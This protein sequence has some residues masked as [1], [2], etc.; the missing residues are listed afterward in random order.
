MKTKLLLLVTVCMMAF[1]V[2]AQVNSVA[3][4]GTA[5]GGW[6][7]EPGN[8]G[9]TDINQLT[10]VDADNWIIENITIAA[11]PCKLRANNCWCGAGFEWAG[12]FPT[13]TGT[14]SGDIIVPIAGVYTVTL[15]ATT[16]VYNFESGSP[17]PVVKLIGSSVTEAGGI[18]LAPF[19]TDTFRA[20]NVT[21]V[22]GTGQFDIDG[23]VFG[24]TS[25]PTGTLQGNADNIPVV[26][27]VYSTVTLNI[28]TGDYSFELAPL[29]PPV[30]IVGD[31]VGGW[32]GSTGNPGPEDT[33]QL[34][35]TD[36]ENYKIEKLACVVGPAK[37]RQDNAWT[38]NWGD[39][40][41]PTGTGTQGGPDIPVAAAGTY[42][43]TF[44]RSTGAYNF[45]IP[46][47]AIV[48]DAVGGWPGSTGN[49]GPEDVH[50]MATTDGLTYTISN[51]NVV[52][53]PAKFRQGNAWDINWGSVDF[54]SG[55]ATQNGADISVTTA[56]TYD[57]TLNRVTG[58]YNFTPS[59]A[60]TTFNS[61]NF[62][63]SPN[64][65]NN[66]WNF[67]SAKQ[68]IESIQIV[69]MLGKTVMTINPKDMNVTVDATSLNAGMYFAKISTANATETAKLIKN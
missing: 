40:A 60:T 34:T 57:V 4:V 68:A 8:P 52:V 37:F 47:I 69:D 41:F 30:S 7:G 16:G 36:G 44:V 54:P 11:G 51:L 33:N 63:V 14:S 28:S 42:D 24:E 43:I 6:P 29:I 32:P 5:V 31:A 66:V 67:V 61:N 21:L 39:T 64:P 18:V 19:A 55:T 20:T 65:T 53:G 59:L 3:L 10:Q 50:Q 58:E 12:A 1:G 9:P 26:A 49:P 25:F 46:T 15:N 48:G 62:R 17:L 38:I 35:S 23:S 22:D 56:G 2:N 45:L 27:G 13:A